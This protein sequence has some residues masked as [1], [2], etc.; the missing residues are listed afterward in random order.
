MQAPCRGGSRRAVGVTAV[1]IFRL[2]RTA[3]RIADQ[4]LAPGAADGEAVPPYSS[5]QRLLHTDAT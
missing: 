2:S 1:P 3:A 4:A 5:M